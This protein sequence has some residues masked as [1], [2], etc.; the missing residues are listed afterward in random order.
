[1]MEMSLEML[2]GMTGLAVTAL[3]AFAIY[4]WN[5][6]A[7]ARGVRAWVEEFLAT[8]Y[9]ERPDRLSVNCSD[10]E[11]W[12]VLVAFDGPGTGTRHR[13]QFA[14]GGRPP[15]LTLLSEVEDKR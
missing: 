11:L 15:A 14:C 1:M 8:R 3:T 6:R 13:L 2:V 9:G 4:R 12:P 7:R 5:R 10:D